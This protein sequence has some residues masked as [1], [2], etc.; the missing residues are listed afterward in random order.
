MARKHS[1]RSSSV[2]YDGAAA[3][4]ARVRKPRGK[5]AEVE[6]EAVAESAAAAPA[7]TSTSE[8]PASEREAIA[9]LAYSYYEARGYQGGSAEEDWLRAEAEYRSRHAARS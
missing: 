6:V 5:R 3:A 8:D 9:R 7:P 2:G 4:P 1:A